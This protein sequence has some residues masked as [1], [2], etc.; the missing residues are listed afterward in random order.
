[1]IAAS[2]VRRTV[3]ASGC[4]LHLL[5]LRRDSR[6]AKSEGGANL[7]FTMLNL[8]KKGRVTGNEHDSRYADETRA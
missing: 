7:P 5:F 8:S 2:A 6:V 4:S 1:M 3:V